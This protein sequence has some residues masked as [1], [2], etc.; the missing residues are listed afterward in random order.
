MPDSLVTTLLLILA[1]II[2]LALLARP[3][4]RWMNK[5]ALEATRLPT[6]HV[7][8]SV[9]EKPRGYIAPEV[10]AI[11]T[12]RIPE[13][14]NLAKN[15]NYPARGTALGY[16]GQY[17]SK[18]YAKRNR[19]FEK[20]APELAADPAVSDSVLSVVKIYAERFKRPGLLEKAREARARA[21][22]DALANRPSEILLLLGNAFNEGKRVEVGGKVLGSLEECYM[23]VTEAPVGK[24]V[25]VT[26]G[27]GKGRVREEIVIRPTS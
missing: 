15:P 2:V 10:Y 27:T 19:E 9:K 8:D 21:E 11:P 17:F 3:L 26:I 20:V 23:A 7:P 6:V 12:F 24:A 4:V 18:D 16:V 14:L 25:A 13:L 22:A 5:K 1:G